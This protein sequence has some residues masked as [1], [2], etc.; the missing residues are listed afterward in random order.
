MRR[1]FNGYQYLAPA[2]LVPLGYW[3]WWRHYGEN[4]QMAA[5][6]VAVPILY[7]YVVPA[8]GTNVL[9]MW[10]FNTRFRLGRFRAHHGFVFG[11]ATAILALPAVGSP[12]PEPTL[13][14]VAAA[15]FLVASVLAFWN[16]LY[17]ILAIQAGILTVYNQPH[18][19]GAGAEAVATD[20]API[21]FGA[22]GL[23]F[24]CGLKLAEGVL[25][26]AAAWDVWAVVFIAVGI[27]CMAAPPLAYMAQS[28]LRHGHFGCRPMRRPEG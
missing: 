28:W 4:H 20:Y 22:F 5:F 25:L 27:P 24:G 13:A 14:D 23:V 6:A 18:A 2:V 3:L 15:G 16:W 7:A 26:P 19:D 9:G 12:T 1:I 10:E 21:F 11:G 17:D 8:I